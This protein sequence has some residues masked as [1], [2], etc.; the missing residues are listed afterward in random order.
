MQGLSEDAERDGL[1]REMGHA[2]RDGLGEMGP[3]GKAEGVCTE[4]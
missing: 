1:Q 2:E 3:V 4:F